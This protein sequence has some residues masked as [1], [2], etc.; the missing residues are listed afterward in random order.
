MKIMN[1]TLLNINLK[2]T[3]TIKTTQSVTVIEIASIKDSKK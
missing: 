3:T 1:L 2:L